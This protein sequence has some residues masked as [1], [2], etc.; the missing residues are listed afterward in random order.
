MGD[1]W[2][3]MYVGPDTDEFECPKPEALGGAMLVTDPGGDGQLWLLGN[4]HRML[5]NWSTVLRNGIVVP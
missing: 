5:A 2:S 1:V 3:L 4:S